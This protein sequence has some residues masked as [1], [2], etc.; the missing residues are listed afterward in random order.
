[1]NTMKF[2]LAGVLACVSSAAIADDPDRVH[3]D[4]HEH[5]VLE[6]ILVTATP[7]AKDALEMTQSA[8]VLSDTVLQRELGNSL[9]DTL[10][11][12]PGVSSASFGGNVGR[13]VIRGL[14]ASRVGV[15]ENNVSSNDVSKISQ[16]HAVSIEPFLAEQIEVLRGP[17]TLL[18]G[19]D[20]IGG[21]VNV[22]TNRIPIEMQ[23]TPSGRAIVQFDSVASEQYGAGKLKWGAGAFDQWA[24]HA[25]AFVRRTDD[26]KIPG[27]SE[28]DPE[29]GE[30][31]PGRLLNSALDNEGGALGA[32]WFG[33]KWR[34]GLSWSRYE[35]DY[36]IPGEGHHHDEDE[37]E[38]EHEEEEEGEAELVSIDMS[39]ERIDVEIEADQPFNGFESFKLL[40]NDTAYTHTEFEGDEVGTVFDNDSQE[41]RLEL[42]HNRMGDWRGVIG[43]HLRDRAFFAFGEEAFVPAS[44]TDTRGLFLLEEAQFENVRLDLGARVE[45]IETKSSDGRTVSHSPFSFSVGALWHV[46]EKSHIAVNLARAQRAPGDQELFSDG[47]HVATQ[48]F[49]LGDASLVEETSRSIEAS[50][51]KHLGRL[52]GAF[53]LY[54]NKFDDFIYLTE[55]GLEEDELPVRQWTQADAEFTGFELELRY[56][57]GSFDNGHWQVYALAD[58]VTASLSDGSVLPRQP[59]S[60]WGL[61][62]EWDNGPWVGDLS[63]IKTASQS[64]VA[65]F[66]SA[67]SSWSD[68]SASLSWR[69]A[70]AEGADWELFIKGSNLLDEEIRNHASFLKDQ[71]P[72]AGRNFVLGARM[73]FN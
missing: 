30:E 42:T 56:D 13:P 34:I 9:G 23:E 24:F 27:Y 49:E 39:S 15:M 1:M 66:E 41:G 52:T 63:L 4:E 31:L 53:T 11:N 60:K 2:L 44:N 65:E 51:R 70:N 12:M 25:D 55:T 26:Y 72:H 36:G 61:G 35:S 40:L 38:E 5:D 62:V 21:V 59:P 19:S 48:T 47:P 17:A 20:T 37:H 73:Y 3:G 14:D 6:E 46:N 22:R 58:N 28:T 50:F 68:L 10:K 8:S 54:H 16:D 64:D 7:L 67:T 57:V 43:M 71:A 18:Y 33:E 69:P 29:E 32:S 45:D